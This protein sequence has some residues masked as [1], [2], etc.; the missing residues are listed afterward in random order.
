MELKAFAKATVRTAIA[1]FLAGLA[2]F[3]TAACFFWAKASYEEREAKP[4][5]AIHA[6]NVDMRDALALDVKGKTKLVGSKLLVSINLAGYPP[7]MASPK[8]RQAQL[9]FDFL[10]NDGFRVHTKSVVISDFTSVVGKDG[11]TIGLQYQFEDYLGLDDYKRI[12]RLDVG[13]TFDVKATS[14]PVAVPQPPPP[15][16]PKLD[17]CAPGLSRAERMKRLAQYGAVRE[18]GPGMYTAGSHFVSFF[19]YDGSLLHCS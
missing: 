9:I 2:L 15:I 5:E 3:A 7:Y 8:N 17:H 1:L 4:Y 13:W 12:S 19:T 6:W 11:E 18:T 16:A 14:T 10:D